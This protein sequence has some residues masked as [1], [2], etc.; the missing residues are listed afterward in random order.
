MEWLAT[1]A[2]SA[3]KFSGVDDWPTNLRDMSITL[4]QQH[5]D[6][7]ALAI[8]DFPG[9]GKGLMTL[10][11]LR[12]GF[13]RIAFCC[14]LAFGTVP[15]LA[16]EVSCPANGLAL[17]RAREGV[18]GSPCAAEPVLRRLHHSVQQCAAGRQ[19]HQ[20][21]CAADR[22]QQVCAVFHAE[23]PTMAPSSLS[24]GRTASN[25]GIASRSEILAGCI[26]DGLR[27]EL[28][29]RIGRVFAACGEALQGQSASPARYISS[30]AHI[31]CIT[32]VYMRCGFLKASCDRLPSPKAVPSSPPPPIPPTS[33]PRLPPPGAPPPVP[34]TEGNQAPRNVRLLC[35]AEGVGKLSVCS[36][37]F[38]K[39]LLATLEQPVKCEFFL[40]SG[41]LSIKSLEETNKRLPKKP[42]MKLW[43]TGKFQRAPEL[44]DGIKYDLTPSSMVWATDSGEAMSLK[45]LV[46]MLGA[47]IGAVRYGAAPGQAAHN[48]AGV[49]TTPVSRNIH[50][51]AF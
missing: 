28:A 24:S 49:Q 23:G 21:L 7:H 44:V 17:H 46:A 19:A 37:C 26:W 5:L 27:L 34:P 47:T 4:L 51:M 25:V 45:A 33:P 30:L 2:D 6:A 36:I 22:R 32:N 50:F 40:A 8:R 31:T 13:T 41:T 38:S 1:S 18:P 3:D 14:L 15:D 20:Y 43:Q 35:V 48:C 9:R 10:K 11:P 39:V 42:L 29:L 16:Q 12:E